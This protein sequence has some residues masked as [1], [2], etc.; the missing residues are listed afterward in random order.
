MNSTL[1]INRLLEIAD[2]TLIPPLLASLP[3][4]GRI[5]AI[6]DFCEIK[7]YKLI[8]VYQSNF[9]EAFNEFKNTTDRRSVLYFHD[10][11]S[12]LQNQQMMVN[13]HISNPIEFYTNY[14]FNLKFFTINPNNELQPK[15]NMQT[16][17]IFIGGIDLFV[18]LNIA[19]LN[20]SLINK[21]II[22]NLK[23]E[24]MD[25]NEIMSDYIDAVMN[26]DLKNRINS[27]ITPGAENDAIDAIKLESIFKELIDS[28]I[29]ISHDI[30]FHNMIFS[31]FLSLRSLHNIFVVTKQY[32]D[33]YGND[34]PEFL[35][36]LIKDTLGITITQT[37]GF[38]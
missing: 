20:R 34:Q 29:R 11:P 35:T 17:P 14:G 31:G 26:G 13:A 28:S 33:E 22:V 15:I 4:S 3:G 5:S 27:F 23:Y 24:D 7:N 10:I 9:Q 37:L 18:S 6:Q 32:L 21:F 19:G 38:K 30:G 8:T 36:R 2:Q 25:E 16:A 12:L 1:L